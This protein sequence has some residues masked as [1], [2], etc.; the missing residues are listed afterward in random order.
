VPASELQPASASKAPRA[1]AGEAA[2]N[3]TDL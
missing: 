1:T 3:A 2:V